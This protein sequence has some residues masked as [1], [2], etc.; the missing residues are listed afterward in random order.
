MIKKPERSDLIIKNENKPFLY[1]FVGT[2]GYAPHPKRW[3]EMLD[4]F[5]SLENPDAF[6]PYVPGLATSDWLHMHTSMR[7]RHMTWVRR[8]FWIF[9][10]NLRN[11]NYSPT[12]ISYRKAIFDYTT[13]AV[14]HLPQ[15]APWSIHDVY[16]SSSKAIFVFQ[17][18]RGGITHGS[19]IQQG[20]LSSLG[21][22]LY[23]A[24][25]L[26]RWIAEGISQYA[27]YMFSNWFIW[28]LYDHN[29]I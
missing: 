19:F 7:K 8:Y 3:R 13:G 18:E 22:L 15:W 11:A 29:Y 14:A 23:R 27:K 28:R 21:I 1:K 16:N 12:E 10:F 24:S 9:G 20:W 6:D 26:P 17:L 2:W 4:W 25:R 5:Y